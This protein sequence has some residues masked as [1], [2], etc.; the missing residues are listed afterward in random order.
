MCMNEPPPFLVTEE[1]VKKIKISL[2][3]DEMIREIK[4]SNLDNFEDYIKNDVIQI[5]FSRRFILSELNNLVEM[6]LKHR[7]SSN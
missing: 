6:Q 3:K 2:L 5:N 1:L 7:L 4:N